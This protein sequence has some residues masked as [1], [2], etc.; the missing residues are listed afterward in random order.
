[1]TS[2]AQNGVV[3]QEPD[4]VVTEMPMEAEAGPAPNGKTPHGPIEQLR[5]RARAAV[6]AWGVGRR[7][8]D[9]VTTWMGTSRVARAPT[10]ADA[11]PTG[12]D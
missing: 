11:P 5:E 4:V 10:S 12:N 1:M 8:W 9:R 2:N 7:A 6:R 3:V